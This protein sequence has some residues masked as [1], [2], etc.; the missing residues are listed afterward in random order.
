[1]EQIA[2]KDYPPTRALNPTFKD[3]ENVLLIALNDAG[4]RDTFMANLH[5]KRLQDKKKKS[6]DVPETHAGEGI[7]PKF[8]N[9][10]EAAAW[11]LKQRARKGQR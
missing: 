9:F 2:K 8:K 4:E 11:T 1:M 6:T 10:D 7:M 5:N 3:W